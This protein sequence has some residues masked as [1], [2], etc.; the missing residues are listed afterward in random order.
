MT[1]QRYSLRGM[2][3]LVS[4]AAFVIIIAGIN[5]AKSV[6][7][8]CLVSFFLALLGTPPVLWLKGKRIPSGFAVLIVMAGLIIILLLISTQIGLSLSGFSDELPLLQS[9]IRE[10]IVELNILLKSKGIV[11]RENFFLEYFN[12]E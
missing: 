3:I 5:L 11:V 9:R 6:V 10:Q 12:Q 4:V 7:V 2:H 8:L 1:E